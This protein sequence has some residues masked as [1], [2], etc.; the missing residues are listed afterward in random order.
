MI[1]A[2]HP[3][4]ITPIE[5]VRLG[6]PGGPAA[7]NTRLGWTLQGP[8]RILEEKLKSQQCLHI[9]INP[10][11]VEL[12]QNV[13]RLWQT[14]ILPI[15]SKGLVTRLKQDQEALTLLQTQTMRVLVDGVSRYATPLLRKK[16][17]ALLQA[18]KEA[19]LPNLRSTE[20]CL[21]R[22]TIKAAAYKEEIR[23]LEVSGYARKLPPEEVNTEGESWF[24]PHHMVQHNGKNRVV[25]NCSFQFRGHSLNDYLL[26]GPVLDPS[27]LGVLLRFREH[28]VA[29][30]GDRKGMFR[31]VRLLPEDKHLL[32][33]VWR[34]LDRTKP[35]DV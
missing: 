34:D 32:R 7:I 22:D 24:I 14:Y 21:E 12:F 33:F 3:H 25:F 16:D 29:V 2:D 30:S 17:M 15:R 35:P 27:L 8:A 18:F 31:Q 26:P 4:L 20:K 11:M 23:K 13:E 19:V 6:P 10:S 9:T 28:R 1:G 5:P